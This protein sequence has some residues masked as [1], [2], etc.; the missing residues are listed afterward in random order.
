MPDFLPHF[1]SGTDLRNAWVDLFHIAHTYP[2]GG[3]DMHFGV[4]EI[5]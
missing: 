5:T 2:L 3:V 4:Y 1:S